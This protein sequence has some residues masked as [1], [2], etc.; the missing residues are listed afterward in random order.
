MPTLFDLTDEAQKI[1]FDL[2]RLDGMEP[3]EQAKLRETLAVELTAVEVQ[4]AEKVDG[5]VYAYDE[6]I[7]RAKAQ[8]DEARKLQGMARVADNQANHLKEVAKMAA[9]L[10][11]RKK[12][13]GNTREI[14]V[15]SGGFAVKVMDGN[16]VPQQFQREIPATWVV[17]KKLISDHIKATGEVPAGVETREVIR[18]R[19]K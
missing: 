6:L 14:V 5:Y 2:E 8:K 3:E 18:V 19:F 17:E 11:D 12:L 4:L 16:A 9:A 15:S 10:L 1:L 13:K 7:A